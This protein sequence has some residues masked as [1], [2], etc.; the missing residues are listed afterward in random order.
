MDTKSQ[1]RALRLHVLKPVKSYIFFF[2]S[3]SC[4]SEHI[5]WKHHE[6][7]SFVQTSVLGFLFEIAAICIFVSF[8]S[9][10]FLYALKITSVNY[11]QYWWIFIDCFEDCHFHVK[12][13]LCNLINCNIFVWL[14]SV[15]NMYPCSFMCNLQSSFQPPFP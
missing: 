15:N 8:V 12:F 10:M 3:W 11:V 2:F 1:T 14:F 7:V 4:S 6:F 9:W 13:V 5:S